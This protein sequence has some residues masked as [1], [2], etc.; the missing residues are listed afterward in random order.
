VKV[1]PSPTNEVARLAALHA[2]RI[3]DTAPEEAFDAITRLAAAICEVPIALISLVD[4]NRQWFKS[5]QGLAVKQ[6]PREMGFCAHVILTPDLMEVPDAKQDVRF[7]DHPLVLD[8][9]HIRFY[10][11][12]PISDPHGYN[13]GSLCVIDRQPKSLLPA[14]RR[15]LQ[16]LSKVVRAYSNAGG[17]KRVAAKRATLP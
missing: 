11:G 5:A 7:K 9:P 3:L 2:Y 14:Q 13:L 8:Q 6:T 4:E 1:S 17:S 15:A 10:A 16:E 12:K